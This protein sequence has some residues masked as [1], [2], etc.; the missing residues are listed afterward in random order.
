M[1]T[2]AESREKVRDISA[3]MLVIVE[4]TKL[5]DAEKLKKL[6]A[7]EPDLKAAQ[8]EVASKEAIDR[9]KA[10]I[11]K[12]AGKKGDNDAGGDDA[13][14]R[15]GYHSLGEQFVKSLGYRNLCEQGLKGGRWTTGDIEL[16]ATLT[17]G[18][19]GAPGG[20]YDLVTTPPNVLPG[21]VDIRFRPLFLEDLLPK[22]TTSSPLIR[23]LVEEALTNAAA[24]V[25]EGD[26]KP[27]SALSFT[28]VDETLHK[29][30]TFLPVTDEMLEDWNQIQSYLD[31]RL[32]LFVRQAA[33]AQ[34]LSG[35]GTGANMVGLLNRPGLAATVTK[36]TAPSAADDNSMDAVYR[37]ITAIRQSSFLEPDAIVISPTAWQDIVLSKNAQGAY[38]ANGPFV[39]Q[40]PETLWGKRVVQTAALASGKALVGAFGQGAQMFAKGG[41]VV[42]ASNSHADFFQ[43]NKT[44]IR[45]ERRLGLAVYRPGAFGLVAGL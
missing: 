17:E 28:T 35:D 11:F 3:K 43:R 13:D 6:E 30:A 1:P 45:A 7:F 19:A 25:A 33:E 12:A 42:E 5:S 15:G 22:G 37:Q 21:I 32:Q 14:K 10:E 36:G 31:A 8:E 27:E 24:A 41:I 26:L 34:L 18:T 23:Y 16:K 39:G 29:V 2:L 44:A 40:Q 9:R 38:Y 20:G 4:D